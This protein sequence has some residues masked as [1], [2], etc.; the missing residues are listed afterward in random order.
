MGSGDWKLPLPTIFSDVRPRHAT[1][2]LCAWGVKIRVLAAARDGLQ[3]RATPRHAAR[4]HSGECRARPDVEK[5]RR[6]T[7]TTTTGSEKRDFPAK[8][9]KLRTLAVA[10]TGQPRRAAA[11]NPSC[12]RSPRCRPRPK[13]GRASPAHTRRRTWGEK[14]AGGAERAGRVGQD[15]ILTSVFFVGIGQIMCWEVGPDVVRPRFE[16]GSP[17]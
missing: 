4:A 15:E 16:L 3:R 12:T 14:C 13:V 5:T 6:G 11:R 7:H 17:R 8:S 9:A 1:P 10:A 2:L